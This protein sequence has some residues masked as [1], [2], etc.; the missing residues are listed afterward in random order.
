MKAVSQL[1]RTPAAAA[2]LDL[3]SHYVA[4][5]FFYVRLIDLIEHY[6]HTAAVFTIQHILHYQSHLLK[7]ISSWRCI[8]Q[9]LAASISQTP[10][11]CFTVSFTSTAYQPELPLRAE[12][13]LLVARVT[14]WC[15][16]AA[17]NELVI[18]TVMQ[19]RSQ[20]HQAPLRAGWIKLHPTQLEQMND[21][22]VA[23]CDEQT[24][25]PSA[26]EG[27]SVTVAAQPRLAL[28][29]SLPTCA[30]CPD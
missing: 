9:G 22:V 11:Q 21:S 28:C 8:A 10:L 2:L 13:S 16:D 30:L 23:Q 5:L 15:A 27:V 12:Q 4:K 14:D 25:R 24:L 19:C 18:L 20:N 1:L 3:S 29:L 7:S 6:V 17:A 26:H